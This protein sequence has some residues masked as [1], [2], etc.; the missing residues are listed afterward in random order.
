MFIEMP[1][2]RGVRDSRF[3]NSKLSKFDCKRPCLNSIHK[4]FLSYM[5][6]HHNKGT[7]CTGIDKFVP[8]QP[9]CE[10]AQEATTE[11]RPHKHTHLTLAQDPDDPRSAACVFDRATRWSMASPS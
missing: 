1:G 5:I 3:P 2:P 6:S 7:F 11:A 10:F 9:A 4:V 8:R